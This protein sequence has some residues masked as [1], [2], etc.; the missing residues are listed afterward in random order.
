MLLFCDSFG[1]ELSEL[2]ELH[3]ELLIEV[4]YVMENIEQPTA[5]H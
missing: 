2:Q 5:V 1:D 3:I 4:M